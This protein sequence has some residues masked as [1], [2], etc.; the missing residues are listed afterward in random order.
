MQSN[1]E[2]IEFK[3][4][5]REI[6]KISGENIRKYFRSDLSIE[7]KSDD[8]PVTIADRSTEE[9][10]REMIMK[11]YPEHGILGEEFGKQNETAEYQWILDPIDGTKSFVYGAVTFGTL[12]ALMKNGT[13][14]LGV[15]HQPIL[16]HYHQPP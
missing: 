7:T 12:I 8:S 3:K 11:E 2:L 10:L 9:K 5:C 4:F 1:N 6:T 14:I 13:P 15:F 16:N